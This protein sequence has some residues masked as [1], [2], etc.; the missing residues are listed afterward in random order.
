M[1]SHG[2]AVIR[3]RRTHNTVVTAVNLAE[4]LAWRADATA[5]LIEGVVARF[6][7]F[8]VKLMTSSRL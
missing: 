6:G 3:Y 8:T 1:D 7:G 2:N 4:A 5:A